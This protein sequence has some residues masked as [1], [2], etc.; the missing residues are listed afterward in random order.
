MP[1]PVAIVAALT[2]CRRSVLAPLISRDKSLPFW[3]LIEPTVNVPVVP[4]WPGL[5]VPAT[6]PFALERV[7]APLIVPVPVK[8]GVALPEAP[9]TVTVD[10]DASEP[11][12]SNVPAL[13]DVVPV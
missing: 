12:T 1:A 3:K 7:T 13:I 10:P 11:S 4:A 6:P 9:P 8:V 5:I 2:M